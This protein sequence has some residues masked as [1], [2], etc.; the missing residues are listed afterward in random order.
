M[1]EELAN[2]IDMNIDTGL[3]KKD[4]LCKISMLSLQW[5][6]H[7]LNGGYGKCRNLQRQE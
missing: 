6:I 7:I 1:F 4:N 5:A 2:A 3:K